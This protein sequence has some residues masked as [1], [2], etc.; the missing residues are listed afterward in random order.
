[1]SEERSFEE[2][3]KK[4]EEIVRRLERGDISLEEGLSAFEEGVSLVKVCQK[5][6]DRASERIKVLT[7]EGMLKGLAQDPGEG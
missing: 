5:Q 6:L 7:Q 2:N 3:I 1:M 4:L